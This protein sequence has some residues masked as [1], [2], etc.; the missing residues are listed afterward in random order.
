MCMMGSGGA[1]GI[2]G[3]NNYHADAASQAQV[4]ADKKKT[5]VGDMGAKD[6]GWT[7]VLG[8]S[9]NKAPVGAS[10]FLGY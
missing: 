6:V 10:S 3:T 4:S 8:S 9:V 1:G 5:K 7:T 2:A